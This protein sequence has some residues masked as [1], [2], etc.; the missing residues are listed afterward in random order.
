MI[1]SLWAA[2]HCQNFEQIQCTV[3]IGGGTTAGLAA[4]ITASDAA[5][6]SNLT[7]F[8]VCLLEPTDW[9]GGQLTASAV[10]AIDFGNYNSQVNFQFVFYEIHQNI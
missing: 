7:D 6:R 3:V 2:V 10:S 8:T 4:A 1:V 5:Y 9:P